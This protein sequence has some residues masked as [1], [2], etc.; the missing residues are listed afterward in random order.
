MTLFWILYGYTA[1][2][3]FLLVLF[4]NE[5]KAT[6]VGVVLILALSLLFPLAIPVMCILLRKRPERFK[7]TT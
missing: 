2:M 4:L 7:Q 3:W 5:G 1:L 6:A